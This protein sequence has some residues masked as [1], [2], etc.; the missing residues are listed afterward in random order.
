MKRTKIFVATPALGQVHAAHGA[1]FRKMEKKYGDKIEFVW[2]VDTVSRIFHDFA[3]NCMVEEF[4]HDSD[5]DILWFLDSDVLPQDHVLDLVCG[6]ETSWEAAGA[7]YPVFMI[8]GGCDK[9]QVVFTVY[10]EI[11]GRLVPSAIPSEGNDWVDGLATGCLFLKRSL[12]EKME[13]PYFEFKFNPHSRNMTEGEDIGFCKKL[14]A[15]GV[16]FYT[17]YGMVCNHIKKVGLLDVNN[18]AIQFSNR[19]VQEVIDQI[20]AEAVA[21]SKIAAKKAYELG[22]EAGRKASK[23]SVSPSGLI[24]PGMPNFAT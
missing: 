24:L 8:P 11:Q 17:N 3:R 13:R 23:P 20:H 21:A 22:Y 7:P 14:Q 19:N 15:M 5:A 2:P 16:K 1:F 10:K 9:P 6:P 12:L 4:I 18:Y